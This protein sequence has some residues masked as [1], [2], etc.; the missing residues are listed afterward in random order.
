MCPIAQS[1]GNAK[2]YRRGELKKTWGHF[3][4]TAPVAKPTGHKAY[5]HIHIKSN[6]TIHI[7]N[8]VHKPLRALH[9][10]NVIIA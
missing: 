3:E 1:L 8:K 7:I 5:I 9:L 2:G 6:I 10:H 4:I